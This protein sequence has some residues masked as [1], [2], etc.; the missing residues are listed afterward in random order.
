M[1]FSTPQ[2]GWEMDFQSDYH[3]LPIVPEITLRRMLK[4][5]HPSYHITQVAVESINLR[6]FASKGHA[7]CEVA[8][9]GSFAYI[10]T[11]QPSPKSRLQEGS[12]KGSLKQHVVFSVH[13]F[14][15]SPSEQ[16]DAAET[17]FLLYSFQIRCNAP[18]A[19]PF[20]FILTPDTEELTSNGLDTKTEQLLKAVGDWQSQVHD[21]IYVYNGYWEKSQE[22]W[23][24][25]ESASWND[26]CMDAAT[27]QSIIDDIHGFFDSRDLYKDFKVPWKRGIIFHGLPGN[28]K[29]LSIKALMGD[30][31]KRKDPSV[32]CLY[33]KT[34]ENCRGES[35]AIRSIFTQARSMA[36]CL[37]VFEDLDSLVKE[38]TR[39]YFLNEVDGL[40]ANDGILMI[41]STNHLDKLDPALRDRPSRFDRKYHF[42]LPDL[43]NRTAYAELWRKKI[44][45]TPLTDYPAT[46]SEEIAQLT[47]GFSFAYLNELF[48]S[49]ML[50][51]ARRARTKD[52][53]PSHPEAGQESGSD[54]AQQPEQ[55]EGSQQQDDGLL[56]VFKQQVEVLKREMDTSTK[57]GGESVK[58]DDEG[59]V[60]VQRP[61]GSVHNRPLRTMMAV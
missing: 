60:L 24:A 16:A 31:H 25:V 22:L 18:R 19:Q 13:R 15:W 7:K 33:V 10:T 40:E 46:A 37:L 44:Q 54:K 50:T 51:M 58:T 1:T 29:T 47:E 28:G 5:R 49:V 20:E 38:K 6:E 21:E 9:Q 8:D 43:A 53:G 23:K 42:K 2:E 36:P 35:Q 34:F 55:A 14:A 39:S 27:K 4:E 45:A 26:V 52:K 30:L 32:S 59:I 57:P 48:I 17:E 56:A 12:D 11:Y 3:V 61:A 41:G